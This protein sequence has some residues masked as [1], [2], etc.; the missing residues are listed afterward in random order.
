MLL[1]DT[2]KPIGTW[3]GGENNRFLTT[4][5]TPLL[6]DYVEGLSVGM[7]ILPPK[8]FGGLH[9]HAAAQE[10]WYVVEGTGKLQVGDEVKDIKPGDLIYGPKQVQHQIINDQEE[11]TLKAILILC[12]YGDEK[13][14]IEKLGVDALK[15]TA[16][17]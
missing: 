11:G 1:I 10:I 4:F 7:V 14:I 9:Q 2:N 15:A 17:Y 16:E 3:T 6:Y 8:T 13:N 12:P 5:I